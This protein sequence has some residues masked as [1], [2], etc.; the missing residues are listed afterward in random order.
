MKN[1]FTSL[2]LLILLAACSQPGTLE[3]DLPG[4]YE[5]SVDMTNADEETAA[6]MAFLAG[7]SFSMTFDA[8]GSMTY[9]FDFGSMSNTENWQWK[10][11]GDT[12]RFIKGDDKEDDVYQVSRIAKGWRLENDKQT[13]I[14]K[15]Q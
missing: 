9:T 13:L 8:D 11:D 14:L 12:L 10:A 3:D 7:S 4:K 2:L 15:R 6:G 1:S 5:L